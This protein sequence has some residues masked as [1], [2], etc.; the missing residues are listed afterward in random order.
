MER[1]KL[2]NVKKKIFGDDFDSCFHPSEVG[3]QF[4]QLVTEPLVPLRKENGIVDPCGLLKEDGLHG[5]G[6]PS[7]RCLG[8]IPDDRSHRG[9]IHRNSTVLWVSHPT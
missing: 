4:V 5:V 7:S 3:P 8:V 1:K 2:Q 9:D 6:I